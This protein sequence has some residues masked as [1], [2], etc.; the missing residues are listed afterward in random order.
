MVPGSARIAA[1]PAAVRKVLVAMVVG[2]LWLIASPVNA[3]PATPPLTAAPVDPLAALLQQQLDQQ[4][5]LDATMSS[6]SSEL[7]AAHDSQTSLHALVVA[8]QQAIAQTLS[9]LTTAER[10]YSEAITRQA[11]EK[12]AADLARRHANADKQLL[13]VYLRVGY[14][15]HD[16][17]LSYLLSSS[18]V[19]E[20][21]SRAADLSHL[22]HRSSDMVAQ[23]TLDL[24]QAQKAEAQAAADAATAAQA[25]AL[26]QEQEQTLQQQTQHAHDLID[27]LG[28]QSAATR[29]E[30]NAANRQS[31]AVA[32]QIAQT[33]LMELDRTIAEA[34]QTAWQEAAYYVQNHLGT[35]P[36]NIANPPATPINASGAQL[37]WP[38]RGVK[39]SQPFGPSTYPFEPPFGAFPHFHTG[40]DLAGPLGTPMMA[41]ADGVVVAADASTVGYGNHVII[42][43]AG[44]LLTLYGHLEAMLVK[45]GDSVKAGQVIGLLGS[46]GNSTGPHCHFEVRISGLPVNPL[47]FLPAL[48]AG[49]T[50]P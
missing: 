18:S 1:Y 7:Q 44:G 30:I 50:G 31:L 21:L 46:T 17:L 47:P 22:V 3:A 29:A 41:A 8:N 33:R 45:P 49:A 48:P 10:Q 24:A 36:A 4:A 43:H 32:M 9:Q 39:V 27:Q 14:Q 20:L 34:E 5:Q 23:I 13:A 37:L 25:A 15:T 16:S 38:A 28:A 35:L 11:T 42:A 40:I 2:C 19:S 26:L 12:A 6:L